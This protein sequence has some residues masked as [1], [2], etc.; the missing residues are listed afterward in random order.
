MLLF[1]FC[2]SKKRFRQVYKQDKKCCFISESIS[3]ILFIRVP[4]YFLI[5]VNSYFVKYSVPL[6]QGNK[7]SV[8]GDK[9]KQEQF[10]KRIMLFWVFLF[11]MMSGVSSQTTILNG[12][13]TKDGLSGSIIYA[14]NKDSK[15]MMWFA[16]DRGVDRFDGYHIFPCNGLNGKAV[17]TLAEWKDGKMLAG[18]DSGLWL[19][20]PVNNAFKPAF[21]N[22]VN[23]VVSCLL[24]D[25]SGQIYAGSSNGLFLYDSKGRWKHYLIEKNDLSRK[26]NVISLAP[27]GENCLFV[28][29]ENGVYRIDLRK[30]SV[31]ALTEDESRLFTCLSTNGGQLY[32]GTRNRGLLCYDLKTRRIFSFSKIGTY[33]VKS[34]QI[35]QRQ[36]KMY[37][38]T[39]G[40]GVFI[41]SIPG[42]EITGQMKSETGI[43]NTIRSNSVYSL[44]YDREGILWTG[45]FQMGLDYTLYQNHLFS[46]Y[47][48]PPSFS[49]YHIPVRSIAIHGRQ[50]VIGS[51][52]GLYFVDEEKHLVRHYAMPQLASN[53]IFSILYYK[54]SYLI[55]TG[56]GLYSLNPLSGHLLYL[57]PEGT[58]GKDELFFSLTTGRD[59]SLWAGTTTG[60]FHFG[61]DLKLRGHYLVTNSQLPGNIVYNVYEDK[62]E[63]VWI[64][65]DNGTCIFEPST[66]SIHSD[67]FPKSFP[68]RSVRNVYESTSGNFYFTT[69][70]GSL[71]LSSPDLK[72]IRPYIPELFAD[73]KKCMFLAEDFKQGLWIGTDAG[74]FC[75]EASG[76]IHRFTFRDGIPD[77]VFFSCTPVKDDEG[78]LWF[79]NSQGL[80]RWNGSYSAPAAH[81]PLQVT[82]VLVN[83]HSLGVKAF[84]HGKIKISSSKD[85]LTFKISDFSYTDPSSVAYEYM[86]EGQDNGWKQLKSN[87]DITYYNL[88]SGFYTL[89]LRVAGIPSSEVKIPVSI[90]F[91]WWL[92]VLAI[93]VFILIIG[94]VAWFRFGG[95]IKENFQTK[96]RKRLPQVITSTSPVNPDKYRNNKVDEENCD[97]LSRKLE[98]L[99]QKQ[100]LYLNPDLKLK[101]LADRLRVPVYNLSYVL[102][103]YMC[104]R[105]NDYVNNYRIGEFK[106]LVKDEKY[107]KYT[108]DA[109]SSLCGFSSKTSFFR[110][111]KRMEGIAPGEYIK[112]LED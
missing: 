69:K 3:S 39:D 106:E 74:L 96:I 89:K 61:K 17:K 80:L 14:I 103:I 75:H 22:E 88:S 25:K 19:Y 7:N 27:G 33:T 30:N 111:F 72:Q 62:E 37:V 94:R 32:I 48:F 101:D 99:M 73:G 67:L 35:D 41:I 38:A 58:K 91:S 16:S 52:N 68:W 92:I 21:R 107:R 83:N 81:Y 86:L 66:Q 51:R 6:H 26:N 23:T 34:L 90:G 15:G 12:L 57:Q 31:T 108:L 98:V 43:E 13:T 9:M 47:A 4:Y 49:S 102:N 64:T 56:A 87:S 77:P 18:N 95:L 79:G 60:V 65:T 29:G 2:K 63:R 53:M 44:L 20:D 93:V 10:G 5:P 45:Y 97:L 82:D 1:T 11:T 40:G 104:Q 85:E 24:T 28:V 59:G 112:Q 46:L 78:M 84:E 110:N 105:F 50:R 70:Q 55:G 100:K 76:N 54:G 8:F 109:L 71:L 42:G 36:H